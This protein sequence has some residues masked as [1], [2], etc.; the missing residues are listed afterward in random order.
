MQD[1]LADMFTRIRNGHLARLRW[2]A[3]PYSGL[4]ENITRIL[5]EEGYIRKYDIRGEGTTKRIIIRLKYSR[6]KPVIEEIRRASRPGLRRYFQ[7]D[8]LVPVRSGLGISILSTSKGVMTD[9]QARRQRVGGE[10]IGT[11]F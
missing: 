7:L 5:H 8:A 2:V 1:P 9:R 10:L 4:K 6:G 3:V 11:V